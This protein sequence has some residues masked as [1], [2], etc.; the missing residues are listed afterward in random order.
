MK[1]E[2]SLQGLSL[3]QLTANNTIRDT[4]HPM[5][6]L[7]PWEQNGLLYTCTQQNPKELL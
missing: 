4:Q 2:V 1:T 5:A 6:K 7:M 3:F